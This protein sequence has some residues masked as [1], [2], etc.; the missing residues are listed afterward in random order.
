MMKAYGYS[1][2]EFDF[3]FN[4]YSKRKISTTTRHRVLERDKYKCLKCGKEKQLTMDCIKPRAWGGSSNIDN[5]QTLCRK[6]NMEKS[7]TEIDYRMKS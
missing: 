1:S 5:L 7:D 2:D 3:D 4:I 6:C